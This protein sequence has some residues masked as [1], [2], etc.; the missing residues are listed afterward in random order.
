MDVSVEPPYQPP[1][2]FV[3]DRK[4]PLVDLLNLADSTELW[5]IQWPIN[6]PP[7]FDGLQVSLNLGQI[8]TFEGSSGKS[9]EV[10]SFKPQGPEAAVFLSSASEAK[11]AGK[12]SR[13]VSLIHYPDPSELQRRNKLNLIQSQRSSTAASTMSGR[14]LAT[15]SCSTK[16][17]NSP[18]VS[19][20]STP[21]SRLKSSVSG[22]LESSKPR[23]KRHVDE[24]T[25]YTDH[26]AQDSGKGNRAITSTGSS[27][28]SQERKSKKKKKIEN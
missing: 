25:R 10:V 28:H 27:E 24:Q 13:C 21:S 2:G 18:A 8:C 23:K 6:Q 11:I 16:P 1:V 3:K 5:L 7:D 26:S 17:R 20:Y 15:P 14:R 12:I 22:Y 9:Y 19:G 4:D